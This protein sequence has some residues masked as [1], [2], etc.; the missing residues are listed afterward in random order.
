MF[1]AKLSQSSY[2][3]H[4]SCDKLK[5]YRQTHNMSPDTMSKDH[6]SLIVIYLRFDLFFTVNE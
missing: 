2:R 4:V 5:V 3:K 6:E 1:Y